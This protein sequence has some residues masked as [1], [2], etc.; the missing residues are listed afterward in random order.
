[1]ININQEKVP[2]KYHLK[3][4]KALPDYPTVEDFMYELCLYMSKISKTNEFTEMT[5][6][7]AIGKYW[8]SGPMAQR[9]ED[10]VKSGAVVKMEDR[11]EVARNP[12]V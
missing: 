4:W 1:M 3:M 10:A 6:N 9:L 2:F 5:L 7:G 11:Y 8:Q 12:F